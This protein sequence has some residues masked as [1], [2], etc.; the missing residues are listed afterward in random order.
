MSDDLDL[1]LAALLAPPERAP[2]E[3]FATRMSRLVVAEERLRA[4]RRRAWTRFVTMMLATAS[5]LLLFILLARTAPGDSGEV[6]GPF[7][8]AAAGLLLLALWAGVASA[9]PAP[10][11]GH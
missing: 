6:V 9:P 3:A 7:S 11:H 5:L 2:D 10:R 4:A 1:R 8:R